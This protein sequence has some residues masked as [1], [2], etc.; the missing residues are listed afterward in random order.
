MPARREPQADV[1]DC[2]AKCHFAIND[3]YISIYYYYLLI[4]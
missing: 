1:A 3:T 4:K 2:E